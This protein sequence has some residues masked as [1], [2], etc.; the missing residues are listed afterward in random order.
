MK[1]EEAERLAWELLE[2]W[3][4]EEKGWRFEWDR[5]KR[6][7]GKC[8]H[9]RKLITVSRELTELN[10]K[11]EGE[12]TIRHEV[13]HA[14]CKV[15]AG[16]GEEWKRKAREVGAKVERTYD[17]EKVVT[18]KKR[19]FRAECGGCGMVIVRELY[20]KPLG[21]LV[22]GVCRRLRVRLKWEEQ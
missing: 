4:L 20:R 21:N 7:F 2:K 6:R 11:E 19:V 15:G 18:P 9:R 10:G 3:G 13:A 12:D 16:H 17:A 22:H 8:S 1:V 5:A 14:L